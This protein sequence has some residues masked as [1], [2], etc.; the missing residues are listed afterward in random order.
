MP[1][2]IDEKRNFY[3]IRLRPPSMFVDFRMLDIGKPGELEIVRGKT[4]EGHWVSQSILVEKTVARKVGKR[5]LEVRSHRIAKP[6]RILLKKNHV[7][8]NVK[9]QK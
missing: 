6:L 9:V 8:V 5:T 1:E 3:R 7:N 4:P 2:V